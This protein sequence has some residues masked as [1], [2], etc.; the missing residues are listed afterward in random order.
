MGTRSLRCSDESDCTTAAV[1]QDRDLPSI[2]SLALNIKSLADSRR[3]GLSQRVAIGLVC[4]PRRPR[5]PIPFCVRGPAAHERKDALGCSESS[6]PN[7]L[8]RRAQGPPSRCD[9]QP[10]QAI[11][12]GS[13]TVGLVPTRR[14][15]FGVLPKTPPAT[16]TL[17]RSWAA[18][19]R[20]QRRFGM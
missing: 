17:L 11:K 13:A 1:D 16:D 2:L 9:Y 3:L 14:N 10:F 20:T 15:R 19:P 6:A 5:P 18:G 4:Y 8:R 7:L 12:H